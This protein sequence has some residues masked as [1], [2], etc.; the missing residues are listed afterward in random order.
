MNPKGLTPELVNTKSNLTIL[1]PSAC[2]VPD[3]TT[4]PD[5]SLRHRSPTTS[6]SP[7]GFC[8]FLHSGS[9]RLSDT[10]GTPCGPRRAAGC[11][12]HT[13]LLSPSAVRHQHSCAGHT[14]DPHPLPPVP[15][16]HSVISGEGKGHGAQCEP[17]QPSKSLCDSKA[18]G[19]PRQTRPLSRRASCKHA[20]L[21]SLRQRTP[22][23][24][25]RLPVAVQMLGRGVHW[26][27][28]T[29]FCRTRRLLKV[30]ES[31]QSKFFLHPFAL[32]LTTAL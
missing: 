1:V 12:A 27:N 19:S 32:I 2:C 26:F 4:E 31:S 13:L 3:Q 23:A 10:P 6:A 9:W 22:Q 25:D 14:T 24:K 8:P 16:H 20:L 5:A 7:D 30:C 15:A 21:T 28:Y 11:P 17:S 29:K 18:Q